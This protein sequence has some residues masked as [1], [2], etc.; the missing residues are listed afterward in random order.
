MNLLDSV[1]IENREWPY[2]ASGYRDSASGGMSE[3]GS[4][5]R[6]W[7]CQVDYCIFFDY[8]SSLSEWARSYYTNKRGPHADGYPVRCQKAN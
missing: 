2:P 4:A 5:G 3:V 6:Y 1:Y 7:T 8:D